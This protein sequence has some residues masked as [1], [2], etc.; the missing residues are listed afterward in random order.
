M[1]ATSIPEAL[2][3]IQNETV[4]ILLERL[5]EK[6]QAEKRSIREL[7]RY[8][9]P[10]AFDLFCRI[11]DEEKLAHCLSGL[12]PEVRPADLLWTIRNGIILLGADRHSLLPE[13]KDFFAT[14]GDPGALRAVPEVFQHELD[15]A[16]ISLRDTR[17]VG[18]LERFYLD[19]AD[20][21]KEF[22]EALSEAIAIF[23]RGQEPRGTGLKTTEAGQERI[24]AAASTEPTFPT[25]PGTKWGEVTITF[26]SNDSIEIRVGNVR[27]VFDFSELGLR[28]R[29]KIDTSNQQWDLLRLL[30]L[31][32]ELK[33]VLLSLQGTQKKISRLRQ[34]LRETFGIQEDPLPWTKHTYS[35]AFTLRVRGHLEKHKEPSDIEQTYQQDVNPVFDRHR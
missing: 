25:P 4:N 13:A 3:F 31:K 26:V 23:V 6:I 5:S 16:A 17:A 10:F 8:Y 15:R 9:R 29:R 32:G 27:K 35:P 12:P 14:T 20:D 34:K 7:S 1:K 28:D 19:L 18:A 33:P 2:G 22:V 11:V 24:D 21:L 30:A